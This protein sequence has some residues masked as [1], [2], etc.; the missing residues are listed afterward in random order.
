MKKKTRLL[1]LAVTLINL[2]IYFKV[3]AL[4]M[5]RS[6]VDSKEKKMEQDGPESS[7]KTNDIFVPS[8]QISEDFAVSF[9]VD[10]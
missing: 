3:S 10:I 8:E 6:D 1:L 5:E 4:E 2:L 9:P 7:P